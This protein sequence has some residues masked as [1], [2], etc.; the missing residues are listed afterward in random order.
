MPRQSSVGNTLITSSNLHTIK[1]TFTSTPAEV[2]NAWRAAEAARKAAQEQLATVDAILL[3]VAGGPAAD[4]EGRLSID[5]R[6]VQGWEIMGHCRAVT[7]TACPTVSL[8]IA[9]SSDGLPLSIQIVAGPGLELHA[10][11]IAEQLELLLS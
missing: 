2:R 7:L 11:D 4:V 6:S 8:P 1:S 3:P 9:M 10:L 5:G